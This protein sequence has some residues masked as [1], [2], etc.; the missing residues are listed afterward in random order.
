MLFGTTAGGVSTHSFTHGI[1]DDG[2][3]SA[4]DAI[5]GVSIALSFVDDNDAAAESV[6]FTF[7]N[8]GFGTVVLTS[9]TAIGITTFSDATTPALLT[10]YLLDGLLNVKL[11]AGEY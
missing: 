1:N 2:Y 11:N 5:T 4:T 7:E 10:S 6:T 3:N 8:I 9:G